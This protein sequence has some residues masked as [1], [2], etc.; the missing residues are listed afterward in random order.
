MPTKPPPSTHYQRHPLQPSKRFRFGT[1]C[2]KHP[3]LNGWR[4]GSSCTECLKAKRKIRY[5]TD[6]NFWIIRLLRTRLKDTLR[7]KGKSKSATT[8]KLTGCTAE[9]LSKHLEE[10]FL[11]GMTWANRGTWHID[12][13]KPCASFDL[14]KPAQQ[15]KCFHYSNLQPL[16]GVDNIRKGAKL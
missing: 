15:R 12:H 1:I 4:R 6:Q 13:I 16:W 2:T 14:T 5:R 11:P 8:L 10:H 9:E 3:H 7:R